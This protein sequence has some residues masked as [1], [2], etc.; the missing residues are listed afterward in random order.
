VHL[1]SLSEPPAEE[2]V[3]KSINRNVSTRER[4]GGDGG[5]RRGE[6]GGGG[7]ERGGAQMKG[8]EM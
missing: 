2:E 1:K 8:K 3:R 4:G 5:E 7:E 6:E